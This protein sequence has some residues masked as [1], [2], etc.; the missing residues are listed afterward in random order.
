[1]KER[2]KEIIIELLIQRDE[3]VSFVEIECILERK[4]ISYFGD[5]SIHM[6]SNKNVK[7]WVG[8]SEDFCKAIVELMFKDRTIIPRNVPSTLYIFDGKIPDYPVAENLHHMYETERWFPIA[9]SLGNL[10]EEGI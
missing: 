7:L 6:P 3:N 9:F 10:Y 5:Y 1:M 2:I 4:G 8:M